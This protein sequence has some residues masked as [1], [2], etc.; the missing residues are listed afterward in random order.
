MLCRP[1]HIATALRH[2]LLEG[3]HVW[4]W[5]FLAYNAM[6]LCTGRHTSVVGSIYWLSTGSTLWH[7]VSVF[8]LRGCGAHVCRD[9]L[10][11]SASTLE[12]AHGVDV[13]RGAA[14]LPHAVSLARFERLRS[15][16]FRHEH[17]VSSIPTGELV[18]ASGLA[19]VCSMTWISIL[20]QCRSAWSSWSNHRDRERG[21]TNILRHPTCYWSVALTT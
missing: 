5:V 15:V 21:R 20:W 19:W 18:S 2:G 4:S 1:C 3:Q 11:S 8:E 13:R 9:S 17:Y 16:T 10:G 6:S 12:E 14:K 7:P